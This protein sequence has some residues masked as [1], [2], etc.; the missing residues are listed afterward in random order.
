MAGEHN[1]S[2][3]HTAHVAMRTCVD[4]SDLLLYSLAKLNNLL[5]DALRLHPLDII[6]SI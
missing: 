4:Y 1:H 6:A 3:L 2:D 5:G